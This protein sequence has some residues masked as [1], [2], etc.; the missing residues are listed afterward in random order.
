MVS[1]GFDSHSLLRVEH[2]VCPKRRLCLRL[3]PDGRL[4]RHW[5]MR[6]LISSKGCG[7]RR[8]DGKAVTGGMSLK[9][10]LIHGPFLPVHQ[11][12]SI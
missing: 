5:L 2:K 10:Y 9:D 1:G 8:L 7:R 4:L 3:L 6:G 11:S 12:A